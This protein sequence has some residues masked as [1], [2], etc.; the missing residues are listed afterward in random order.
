MR[1]RT[2]IGAIAVSALLGPTGWLGCGR[3]SPN[4]T[5]EGAVREFVERLTAFQGADTDASALFGLL[6]ARSRQNLVARAERY[7]AATGKQIAPA[8]MLV[9]A[10]VLLRFEPHAYTAHVNGDFARVEVAGTRPEDRAEIGCVL[11]NELWRVDIALPDLAP[12]RTRS[13]D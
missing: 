4:A 12:M 2:A 1:R 6:S 9:P 7:G 13:S 10:R 8:A 5:P 11:E 3:A